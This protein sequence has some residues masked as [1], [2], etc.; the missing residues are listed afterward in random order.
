MRSWWLLALVAGCGRIG[1]DSI[2]TS[3]GTPS[4][5]TPL[6]GHDEDGDGIPDPGDVCPHVPDPAQAD[7]DGDR[8]GDACDREPTNPRQSITAFFAMTP[9][10]MGVTIGAGAWTRDADSWHNAADSYAR[11][12]VAVPIDNV[13]LWF[14]AD[15]TAKGVP[16]YQLAIITSYIGNQPYFY[17]ELYER[18]GGPNVARVIQ[19]D[20]TTYVPQAETPLA[21]GLHLGSATVHVTI[22]AAT[23]PV[24]SLEAGWAGEPYTVSAPAPGHTPQPIFN[25]TVQHVTVDV[26]YV[27]VIATGP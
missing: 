1:F 14:G 13:D 12:E 2:A 4:D 19:Y 17:G 26:R 10:E 16:A 25:V 21:S 5:G 23:A 11:L 15:V 7:Q 24:Y 20:G 18:M 9:E 3:D 22:D 27:I 8:V 6:T